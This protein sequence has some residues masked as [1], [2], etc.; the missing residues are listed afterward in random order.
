M[1]MIFSKT[2]GLNSMPDF[3]TP[4]ISEGGGGGVAGDRGGGGG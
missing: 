3:K 2:T 1:S 4:P